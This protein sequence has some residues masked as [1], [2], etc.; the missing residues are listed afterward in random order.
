MDRADV[1]VVVIEDLCWSI[2][3]ADWSA[4]RPPI[5]RRR[6]RVAWQLDGEALKA[7]RD[8]IRVMAAETGLSP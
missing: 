7:K 4:R 3:T 5:W 6:A 1:A 2:A 8:R